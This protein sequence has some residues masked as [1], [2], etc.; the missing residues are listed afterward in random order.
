MHIKSFRGGNYKSFHDTPEIRFQPG[1]NI[2][3]GKNNSGKS[4]LLELLTL[5]P[6]TCPHR[7]LATAPVH[8]AELNP[9]SWC[10]VTFSADWKDLQEL[11]SASRIA[12]VRPKWTSELTEKVGGSTPEL[13][14]NWILNQQDVNLKWRRSGPD[15][16]SPATPVHDLYLRSG[17]SPPQYYVYRKVATD[18]YQFLSNEA[19]EKDLFKT[20]LV[21]V[22]RRVYRF[23]AQRL[24]STR[25]A[26]DNKSLLAPDASN[27]VS[28]LDNL[29][30][31]P[32]AFKRFTDHVIDILPNIRGIST[33]PSESGTKQIIVWPVIEDPE[34]ERS[35]LAVPL[36]A[37]GSGVAQILAIVY[38][39]VNS[40]IPL[41]LLVDEPNSFLHPA[42][43]RELIALF[44]QYNK[45]Q[46]IIATHSAEVIAQSM[47]ANVMLVTEKH[48]RSSVHQLSLEEVS[49]TRLLLSELGAKLSDVFGSDAI[50]WTEGKTEEECFPLIAER[51]G[52]ELRGKKVLS[53]VSTGDLDGKHP[54]LIAE[55]YSRLSAGS[56]LAP[57]TLSIVLDREGRSVADMEAL[58]KLSSKIIRF[59]PRRLFE[60][61]LLVPDAIRDVLVTELRDDVALEVVT[62]WLGEARASGTFVGKDAD[63][64]YDQIVHG[65]NLLSALFSELSNQRLEYRKVRHGRML[66]EIILERKPQQFDELKQV[67]EVLA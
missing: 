35:D 10:E 27:L 15:L 8:D 45:H 34:S 14:L 25:S 56:A 31:N 9:D 29:A 57:P 18:R 65:A 38:V 47:P 16:S 51:Q 60:N 61:Y 30:S 44:R 67:L 19:N 64:D 6:V 7:S 26:P 48:L 49:E 53:L 4:A 1:I 37:C 36:E 50:L 22:E 13:F 12:L 24:P 39:V 66:T 33:T 17:D 23:Q 55:I 41:I 62:K 2:I 59:L 54:K 43:V 28:V 42:A 40:P 3:A 52:F 21:D 63:G 32:F 46:Y 20:L 11:D 58:A 5:Q